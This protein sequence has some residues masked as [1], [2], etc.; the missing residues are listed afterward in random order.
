MPILTDPRLEDPPD[1]ETDPAEVPDVEAWMAQGKTREQAVAQLIALWE[2]KRVLRTAQWDQQQAAA[3]QAAGQPGPAPAQGPAGPPPNGQI[4]PIP[5][6]PPDIPQPA[7]LVPNNTAAE[8][9][10][11]PLFGQIVPGLVAPADIEYAINPFAL[12]RLKKGE[13]V[14][15]DYFTTRRRRE[16][17]NAKRNS[18]A[19]GLSLASEGGLLLL[20]PDSHRASKD[21]LPDQALSFADFENAQ[22]PLL[23]SMQE[24]RRY[25]SAAV[26]SLADFFLWCNGGAFRTKPHGEAA[27]LEYA[28]KFRAHWHS[29]MKAG[30]C[31]D[32]GLVNLDAMEGIRRSIAERAQ[33]SR[34]AGT[35]LCLRSVF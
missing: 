30:N 14:E 34:L 29:E 31:F 23:K 24:S 1:F 32:I 3:Q 21:I 35:S 6:P 10:N 27:I 19:S 16:Y 15:L 12:N 7:A 33:E 4:L 5:A 13:Y 26:H 8:K 9:D 20:Q 22:T 28:A 18:N 11:E 25:T 2:A 17:F